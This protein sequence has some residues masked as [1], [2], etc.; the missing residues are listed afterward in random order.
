MSKVQKICQGL[1]VSFLAASV[2]SGCSYVVKSGANV[3]LGFTEKHVVPPILAM[4]DAEMVCNT[5][6]ALTPAIMSTKGMGADPTRVAVLM[7]AASGVCAENQ[8]LEQELRYLRAS[9]AGQV[10]EA[11]DG[12]GTEAGC[13]S[14]IGADVSVFL[15]NHCAVKKSTTRMLKPPI[16]IHN[17][18]E[19][20]FLCSGMSKTFSQN[21]EA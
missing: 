11:Q 4:Q 10:T 8:A 2:L 14:T 3:A 21:D 15:K 20:C 17:S 7:Y 9:K 5:G 6:S 16:K 19:F 1:A 12:A 18:F 13:G